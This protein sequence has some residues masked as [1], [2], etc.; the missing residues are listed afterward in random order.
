M[1]IIASG[2][3]TAKT[4]KLIEMAAEAE[5]RGEVCYIVCHSLREASR[6]AQIAK[7]KELSISFPISYDEFLHGRYSTRNIH[8]LYIDNAEQLLQRLSLVPIEAMTINLD[9]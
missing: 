4:T 5:A 6:I 1:N 7:E 8:H 9:E 3:Q 2:R